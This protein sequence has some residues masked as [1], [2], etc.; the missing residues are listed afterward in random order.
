[1][2]AVL[3]SGAQPLLDAVGAALRG[4]DASVT[5]VDDLRRRCPDRSL[6]RQHPAGSVL[7]SSCRWH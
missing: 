5:T 6:E 2:T 7:T 4:R 3:V 1:M